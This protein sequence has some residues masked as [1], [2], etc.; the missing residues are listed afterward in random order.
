MCC[1][2]IRHSQR[3]LIFYIWNAV[4][5]KPRKLQE[6][7]LYKK[8]REA[9][10]KNRRFVPCLSLLLAA[11]SAAAA[12]SRTCSLLLSAAALRAWSPSNTRT[13]TDKH[14]HVHRETHTCPTTFAN[15]LVHMCMYVWKVHGHQGAAD[16]YIHA[17]AAAE[18]EGIKSNLQT[19][20]KFCRLSRS[21]SLCVCPCQ[22]CKVSFSPS[23]LAFNKV[24]LRKKFKN[25]LS[26]LFYT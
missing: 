23:N 8:K 1:C 7:K 5:K 25:A 14:I 3:P 11:L 16:T 13:Q 22:C 2:H 12:L 18:A 20:S 10:K 9:K 21:L 17:D 6:K 26:C 19:R 24:Q 15:S 4:K